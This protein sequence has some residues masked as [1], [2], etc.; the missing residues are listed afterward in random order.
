MII[1]KKLTTSGWKL[2][3]GGAVVLR[4]HLV[5]ESDD[6]KLRAFDDHP[7]AELFAREKYPY[8]FKDAFH[9]VPKE[10]KTT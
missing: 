7:A 3:V 2:Y 8:L 10:K 6:T 5:G 9:W 1:S 4:Y